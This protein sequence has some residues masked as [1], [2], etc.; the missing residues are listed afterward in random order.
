MRRW[1]RRRQ[2]VEAELNRLTAHVYDIADRKRSTD[3]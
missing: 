2:Q 3:P 1:N